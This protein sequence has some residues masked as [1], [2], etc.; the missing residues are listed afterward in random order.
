MHERRRGP[1][2]KPTAEAVAGL[3]SRKAVAL[4]KEMAHQKDS[5]I[6]KLFPKKTPRDDPADTPDEDAV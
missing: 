1:A 3:F 5:V 4:M 2:D 6:L